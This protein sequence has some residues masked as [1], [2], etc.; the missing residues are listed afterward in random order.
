MLYTYFYVEFQNRFK[1]RSKLEGTM[2]LALGVGKL[3]S[4]QTQKF[5]AYSTPPDLLAVSPGF[6]K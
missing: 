6:L 4:L 3:R 2:H 5:S 1:H